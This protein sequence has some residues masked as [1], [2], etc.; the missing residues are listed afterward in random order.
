MNQNLK[1][2]KQKFRDKKHGEIPFVL[3]VISLF[4]ICFLIAVLAGC[5]TTKNNGSE[6]LKA[7]A[8]AAI[9]GI[10]M[11]DNMVT[12][13]ADKPFIY[14]IY[15]PGD[16]YKIVLD[17]PDVSLGAFKTKIVSQ[18]AGI[19]EIIPSQIESPSLLSRLEILLQTPGSVD[20]DYNN[21]VLT[22][23]IREDAGKSAESRPVLFQRK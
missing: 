11:Q 10:T 12:I 17:M 20:Q 22:L 4:L 6:T 2:N 16:P 7:Q 13:T 8:P 1:A 19:T 15:K 21:N 5:A 23:K 14:T 3:H 9:T 18:K